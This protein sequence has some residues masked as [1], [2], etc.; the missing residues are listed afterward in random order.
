MLRESARPDWRGYPVVVLASGPS[1]TLEQ[2]STVLKRKDVKSIAT[3]TTGLEKA[4]WADVLYGCDFLWWRQYAA[5]AKSLHPLGCW[6]TDRASAERWQLNWIRSAPRDGLG[7][8][9]VHING[10]SGAGALNLAVCFGARRI[11]L[12]G[13]D[14]KAAPDGKRHHH[15]EHPKPLVQ[16]S[17]FGEW[18]HKMR[19]VAD[20]CKARGIEVINCTPGSALPYFPF[21]TIEKEL[22]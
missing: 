22:S 15:D 16:K 10:N 8:G 13:F 1:L 17:Q 14:M 12:L 5:K 20:D 6:T 9:M 11:L 19:K 18:V 7:S 2:C 4:P 3:N 21:S